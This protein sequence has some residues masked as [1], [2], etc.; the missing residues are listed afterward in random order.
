LFICVYK[1]QQFNKKRQ[2]FIRS[3]TFQVWKEAPFF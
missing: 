1:R 2:Q 3:D